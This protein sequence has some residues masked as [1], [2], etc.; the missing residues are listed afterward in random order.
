MSAPFRRDGV[1][2]D[3]MHRAGDSG[4]ATVEFALGLPLVCLLVLGVVQVAVV[5]GHQFQ[6]E[7]LARTAAR[8]AAVADDAAAAANGVAAS[9]ALQPVRVE[10]D[11]GDI[12]GV[13]APARRI[14]VV[15]VTITHTDTT[16]VPLVGLLVP[17]IELDATAT[18]PLEPP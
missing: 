7:S 6:L 5:A 18:M 10:V 15:A 2:R 9:G 3:D 4:Q 12:T 17:D 11:V 14:G 1:R 16:D 8:A 13:D